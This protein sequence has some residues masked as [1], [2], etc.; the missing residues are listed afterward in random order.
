MGKTLDGSINKTTD[1][2]QDL[3]T[4]LKQYM[5]ISS[6]QEKQQF[7]AQY[8]QFNNLARMNVMNNGIATGK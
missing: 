8:K 1:T 6:D 3:A 7:T 2:I 5:T 4:M